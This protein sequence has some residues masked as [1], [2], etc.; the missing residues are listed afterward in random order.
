MPQRRRRHRCRRGWRAHE[1]TAGEPITHPQIRG[2]T[3]PCILL[4]LWDGPA[5][6]Y[7]LIHSIQELGVSA[8]SIDTSNIYRT[9]RLMEDEGLVASN[10]A[11]EGSGPARRVYE[12][13]DV[14]RDALRVW[15]EALRQTKNDLQQF[16]EAHARLTTQGEHGSEQAR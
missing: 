14:G 3:E 15:S 5:H 12:I 1:P 4:A 11:T 9:L 6:G 10:W 16:L 13:T 2:F 7:R 8:A